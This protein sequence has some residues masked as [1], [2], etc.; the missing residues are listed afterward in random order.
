MSNPPTGSTGSA[1]DEAPADG[2]VAAA[3]APGDEMNRFILVKR[4]RFIRPTQRQ[5]A[6][7]KTAA[8]YLNADTNDDSVLQAMQATK[9]KSLVDAVAAATADSRDQSQAIGPLADAPTDVKTRS[10]E[11][12][13]ANT[14]H[15]NRYAISV[16]FTS[17]AEKHIR[18]G[19]PVCSPRKVVVDLVA[20][21]I[22][23]LHKADAHGVCVPY[24]GGSTA[25]TIAQA[26]DLPEDAAALAKYA[27]DFRFNKR[28][29]K[30]IFH[31]RIQSSI[32]LQ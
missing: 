19:M 21:I 26:H 2:P 23:S 12:F 25:Q 31:L 18:T 24:D 11:G 14:I 10:I 6:G 1:N 30:V 13:E 17:F 15:D 27:K 29:S 16:P 7:F 22:H 32:S 9:M 28:T 5:S 3:M 8:A 4:K 20:K